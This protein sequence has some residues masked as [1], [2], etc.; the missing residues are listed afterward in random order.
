MKVT[1]QAIGRN[2]IQGNGKGFRQRQ[3]RLHSICKGDLLICC[4]GRST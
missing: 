4:R 2:K 3:A 1:N